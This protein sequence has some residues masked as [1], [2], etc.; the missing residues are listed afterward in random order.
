M[1]YIANIEILIALCH[2]IDE[3]PKFQENLEA[4]IELKNNREFLD[5]VRK[6]SIGKYVIGHSKAKKFYNE[7]KSVIDTINKYSNIY[8]FVAMNYTSSG[9]PFN[10]NSLDYFYEYLLKH[11]NEMSKIIKVLEQLKKLGYKEFEFNEEIDFTK[12]TYNIYC[13]SPLRLVS[14]VAYLDNMLVIPSYDCEPIKYT[15]TGSNYQINLISSSIATPK[16]YFSTIILNSLLFDPNRLPQNTS[17]NE[18]IDKI[19]ALKNE[20]KQEYATIKEAVALSVRIDDMHN[21]YNKVNN[22]ITNLENVAKK[23]QLIEL[24][25][26]IKEAILKMQEISSKHNKEITSSNPFITEELINEEIK[27]YQLRRE[28][29]KI[30]T[31]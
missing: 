12:E 8:F 10:N 23:E 14:E 26:N 27:A 22:T 6:I 25:T 2:I 15:T 16:A 19:Y 29:A 21:M 7:N 5:S 31:W 18:T 9:F 11:K 17:K 30:H 4:A 13:H 28:N 3:F 24:L 1:N 20:K